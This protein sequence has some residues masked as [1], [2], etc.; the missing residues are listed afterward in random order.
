[1][2]PEFG[3]PLSFEQHPAQLWTLINFMRRGKEAIECV[4]EIL[5]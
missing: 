3:S 1:M 2:I 4:I 5:K